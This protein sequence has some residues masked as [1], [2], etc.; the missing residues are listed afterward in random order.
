MEKYLNSVSLASRNSVSILENFRPEIEPDGRDYRVRVF[1]PGYV[2]GVLAVCLSQDGFAVLA[3]DPVWFKVGCLARGQAPIAEP[4]LSDLLSY[5]HKTDLLT[6]TRSTAEAINTSD[7][8]FCC[9]GT[10]SLVDGTLNTDHVRQVCENSGEALRHK[11]AFHILV[12]RST[13]LPVTMQEL[14][15]P[16]LE[17]ASRKTAERDFGV[18]SYPEFLREITA[19]AD[20]YKPGAIV[21]GQYEGDTRSIDALKVL[22]SHT[23]GGQQLALRPDKQE[24]AR[25]SFSLALRLDQAPAAFALEGMT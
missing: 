14:V 18:V 22:V 9:V 3:V 23:C 17:R 5:A 21:F 13:I 12:M 2:G 20:Y 24:E 15:I 10:P 25:A 8:S 1:G 6:M 16:I 11:V 4:G 19:I 7:I